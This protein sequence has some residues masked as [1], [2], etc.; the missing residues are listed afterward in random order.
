[1]RRLITGGA[2]F[3]GSHLA[4]R[5]LAAGDEVVVIDDLSTGS[6]DNIAH[7]AAHRHFRFVEDSIV[8]RGALAG[9][10]EWCDCVFH[11][12]AAVG[13]KRIVSEPVNSIEVNVLGTE[14]LLSALARNP[15]RLLLTSTSEVYGKTDRLPFR[16]DDDL[17]LGPTTKPRW[18]YACSK[19]I[20]EFLAMAYHQKNGLEIVVARLF[21]TVGP[22]QSGRYGMVLPRFV[23]QALAGEPLTVYG[24]GRQSR[25]F[26]HVSDVVG[27][28]VALIDLPAADG[29]VYN[30]GS[31]EEIAILDLAKRVVQLTRSS[32]PI[33]LLPY[34]A[35]YGKDFED[36]ERRVPA[37]EKVNKAIGYR[38]SM[39]LDAIILSVVEYEQ[40]RSARLTAAA[41]D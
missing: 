15:R 31:T 24:D 37:L 9:L 16:E 11:L 20:D 39:A 6:R 26:A 25:C 18:G 17:V 36:L 3:V 28:L 13:V 5:C 21:N 33:Q 4:E 14:M 2:G 1:M 10:V 7:L 40:Q 27:A 38:P 23:A 35:V 8:R 22:R 19:A 34:D 30:V 29:Q 41:G 12:A 32:S